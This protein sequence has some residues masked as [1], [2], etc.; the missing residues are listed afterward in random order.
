MGLFRSLTGVLARGVL[1]LP[2]DA[3]RGQARGDGGK[4]GYA[5]VCRNC[6]TLLGT[7][8]HR[9]RSIYRNCLC[10][11]TIRSNWKTNTVVL[12]GRPCSNCGLHLFYRDGPVRHLFCD[13]QG[14]HDPRP[15]LPPINLR[16]R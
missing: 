9:P 15:A 14:Y 1:A 6:W 16:G 2:G 5:V 4:L 13:G 10:G 3:S 11:M 8:T 12:R 7:N